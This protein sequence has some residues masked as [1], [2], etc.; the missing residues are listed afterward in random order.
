[1]RSCLGERRERVGGL[2]QAETDHPAAGLTYDLDGCGDLCT[3]VLDQVVDAGFDS[4][5]QASDAGDLAIGG[6]GFGGPVFGG[7]ESAAAQSFPAA[8]QVGQ[9]YD[10]RSG[11]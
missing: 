3:A 4:G 8:Q 10:S 1:M 9:I 6:N 7:D 2:S 11:R 5:D